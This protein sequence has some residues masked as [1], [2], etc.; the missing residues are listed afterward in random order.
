MRTSLPAAARTL[1]WVRVLNQL[2]AYALS[3]LAVLAGPNLAGAALVTFGV[4]ALASRW[5]GAFLLD[6]FAPRTILAAGLAATGA[7]LLV[8]T[9]ARGPVQMI[10]AIALV[11]LAFEIYEPASQEL[12]ARAAEG[13]QRHH[14]FAVMGVALSAAGALAGLLA[15]FLL[16][17][18]VRWLVAADALTCLAAAAIALACLPRQARRPSRTDTRRGARWK[19]PARLWR[20]TV[21]GTAFA[22]GYLAVMMYLPLALLERGAPTWLPGLTLTGAA[23]LAPLALWAADGL[24]TGRSHTMILATGAAALGILALAMAVAGSP[25]LTIAAYLASSAVNSVLLGRWQS[26]ISD[27]APEAERP[28]WFAFHGS[29]WGVA[30]PLVPPLAALA[31]TL[32]GAVGAGAFLTAGVAFLLAPLALRARTRQ[33]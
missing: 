19:P 8:L 18:G 2:G 26:M 5:A 3:F 29:S 25:L 12:L 9:L 15:A 23:L 7:A 14:T 13:E 17:L 31:T 10:A 20:L 22:I 27:A 4:S 16:P 21:A 6:G 11:G 28:R 30:Q 32:V 1:V 24:L 33:S